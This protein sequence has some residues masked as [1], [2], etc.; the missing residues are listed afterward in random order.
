MLLNPSILALITVSGI[1]AFMLLLSAFFA[2]QV[3]RHW[4]IMSGSE[5]QLVLERRTYLITTIV[6][7]CFAAELVALLLFIYNAE[8]MSSQFVG[9]MCAT[10]VL[11]VDP[12]GWPTLYLKI[13]IFFFGAAWLM[14]NKIDNMAFDYPLIRIK[15]GLLLLIAPLVVI[16]FIVQI[17]Y[18]TGMDPD[19]IT[20]CCG[21]LF[22]PEGEGVAAELSGVEPATALIALIASGTAALGSGVW[23]LIKRKGGIA[24]AALNAIAYLV[25]L[26][27]IVS[28]VALYIYEHPHHHCPFCILKG[29]HD[30]MGYFL[31]VPLFIASALALGV[32]VIAPFSK[33]PSLQTIIQKESLRY[34]GIS[35]L[36]LIGFYLVAAYAIL[37]SNL[38]MMDVWW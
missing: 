31:Y 35:M 29:G 30:F 37:S 3:M 33:I 23:Y 10:G 20:S 7:Y 2:Q 14:L 19:I 1:V 28:C 32:G 6:A 18:F 17:A 34:I 21:S 5:K 16:E 24:F 36:F 8:Q 13:G 11:N 27:A 22:T 15:Y 9:A 26:V 25:A 12:Y 38:T 4:D